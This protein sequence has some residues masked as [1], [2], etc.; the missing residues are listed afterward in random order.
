VARTYRIDRNYALYIAIFSA[1]WFSVIVGTAIY[2]APEHWTG[3][4][5]AEALFVVLFALIPAA[6][7]FLPYEVTVSDDGTLE[8]RSLLRTRTIR[9]QRIVS[10]TL[11]EGDVELRHDRGKIGMVPTDNF[12]E[13]LRQLLE[14]NPAIELSPGLVKALDET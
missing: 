3:A 1:V 12:D 14:L 8:F 9:A 6:Y 2:N 10:I 11:D 5:L 4:T 7:A 13:F